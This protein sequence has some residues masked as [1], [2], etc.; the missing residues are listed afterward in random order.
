MYGG[1]DLKLERV[2]LDLHCG[3]IFGRYRIH[4]MDVT[5][6]ALLWFSLSGLWVWSSRRRKMKKKKYY[7]KHHR[8]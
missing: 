5:A 1:N 4:L 7:Q 3:R 6:L 8:D 2:M